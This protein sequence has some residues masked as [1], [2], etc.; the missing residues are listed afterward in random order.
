MRKIAFFYKNMH[1]MT[2]DLREYYLLAVE[3][4]K[5]PENQVY[6]VAP[7]DNSIVKLMAEQ[8][9][10]Y[11]NVHSGNY[12]PL[13]D[14][15]FVASLDCAVY[16]LEVLQNI[17]GARVLFW[18]C[19]EVCKE[20]LEDE[21]SMFSLDA[22]R[23]YTVINNKKGLAFGSGNMLL[24]LKSETGIDFDNIF[25]PHSFT[26]RKDFE[27][28]KS[29]KR[30][31]EGTIHIGYV[32][33]PDSPELWNLAEIIHGIDDERNYI[34]HVSGGD[35][36]I[37]DYTKEDSPEFLMKFSRYVP[38]IRFEFAGQLGFER[39]M[40]YFRNTADFVVANGFSAMIAVYSGVPVY[41]CPRIDAEKHTVTDRF[42]PI[43][44]MKEY[45][46]CA[47]EYY[48]Y[49]K[50]LP[51]ISLETVI[52]EN[53]DDKA[54]Q[55]KIEKQY[56]YVS[57][58]H[59]MATAKEKLNEALE[60]CTLT[61]AD[62]KKAGLL[63]KIEIIIKKK[64]SKEVRSY[65]SLVKAAKEKIEYNEIPKSERNKE[66][67]EKRKNIIKK[68]VKAVYDKVK[69]FEK[70]REYKKVYNGYPEKIK[71]I[72]KIYAENKVLKVAFLTIFDSVFPGQPVFEKML[73]MD[74]FDP[75]I[76]VMPDVDKFRGFEYRINTYNKA[77]GE[78][79]KRYGTEHVL[80]GYKVYED[81]YLEL[82]EE[83]PI[84]FFA[85][86]YENMAHPYHD[87]SYFLDKNVLPLYICYGFA[88]L[89]YVRNLYKLDFYNMVWKVFLESEMNYKDY[90]KYAPM[91]GLNTYISGYIKMDELAECKINQNRR[92]RIIISPHHTVM[93]WDKLNLSNFLRYSDFFL[94]LADRYPDIDFVFR[95][96]P[97]LFNNLVQR[98]MWSK[99]RIKEYLDTIDNKPNMF[100]DDSGEYFEL[101]ANSDGMIHDCGSFIGEYL[102]TEKPCCYMLKSPADLENVFLPIGEKCMESYYKAYNQSDIISFIED[103][104][105]NGID[106]IKK[107]RERFCRETLK[108]YHPN[109]KDRVIDLLEKT[110]IK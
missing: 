41:I 66:K 44:A 43:E 38:K 63:E 98:K 17:P 22:K 75:Y 46:L 12:A 69:D 76:I 50:G 26:V 92:K 39:Q 73:A 35:I 71:A 81:E 29:G 49:T 77:Y 51:N 42:C 36:D 67:W 100:Y 1:R 84:V 32:G 106:P 93:G 31:F 40:E 28:E 30:E 103:V 86:P 94:E 16:L 90:V 102:F 27:Y 37:N 47:S 3:M 6:Y 10:K 64:R 96:H 58:N 99:E 34:I 104:V 48:A 72:R 23:L 85:N 2:P 11:F 109:C 5:N 101:F 45:S 59:S 70:A 80:H 107:R 24:D 14:A 4:A 108:I 55:D 54:R 97:M 13:E 9:V 52:E 88:A 53:L 91:K 95:P 89:K 7:P 65:S 20:W 82:G 105:V 57:H 68:P 110:L 15:V 83:Y 25:I 19:S 87:L 61:V 62:M 56:D 21:L 60:K 8:D 33:S 18:N 74:E 78:F 79:S